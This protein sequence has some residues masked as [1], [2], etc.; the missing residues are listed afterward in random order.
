MFT[1]PVPRILRQS[2]ERANPTSGLVNPSPWLVDFFTGGNPTPSGKR[3]TPDAALSFTAVYACV[4][5][6]SE[7]VGSMPF[8]LYKKQGN[9]RIQVENDPRASILNE[10]PNEE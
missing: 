5:A 2:E 9:S 7:P 6:L 10:F 1:I 3:V 4:R 8:H